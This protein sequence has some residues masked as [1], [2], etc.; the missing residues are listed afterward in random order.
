MKETE[1]YTKGKKTNYKN[2]YVEEG[3]FQA[4]AGYDSILSIKDGENCY[5]FLIT[6][7]DWQALLALANTNGRG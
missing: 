1:K 5:S 3:D 2:W 6:P 4:I 7:D